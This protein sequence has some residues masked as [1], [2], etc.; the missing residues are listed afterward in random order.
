MLALAIIDIADLYN[1][2]V[3]EMLRGSWGEAGGKLGAG[4]GRGRGWGGVWRKHDRD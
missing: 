1:V 3:G 2:G 4:E